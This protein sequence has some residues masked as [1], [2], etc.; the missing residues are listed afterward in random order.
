VLGVWH[1]KMA[2]ED[3]KVTVTS[4]GAATIEVPLKGKK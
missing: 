3:V 4:G 1:E 2:A